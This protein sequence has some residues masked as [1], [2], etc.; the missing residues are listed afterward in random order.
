MENYSCLVLAMSVS[1]KLAMFGFANNPF[2]PSI[3]T[4]WQ[5]KV[6]KET[7]TDDSNRD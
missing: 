5:L 4:S 3:H 1:Q 2:V 7:V 6:S